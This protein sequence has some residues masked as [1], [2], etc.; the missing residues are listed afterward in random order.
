MNALKLRV[1]PK[2][3]QGEGSQ[4]KARQASLGR[5]LSDLFRHHGVWFVGVRL[6]RR[7]T[8]MSKA[9][10]ISAI[11]GLVVAQLAFI[12]LQTVNQGIRT[13][14][15]ELVG[16]GF[17]NELL[18]VITKAHDLRRLLMLSEGKESPAVQPLLEQIDTQLGKLEARESAGMDLSKAFKFVH[19]TATSLKTPPDDREDAFRL[20][21]ELVSQLHRLMDSVV[22]E[23]GLALDP[24]IASFYLMRVST[25]QTPQLVQQLGRMRDIGAGAISGI[26][27][28][29]QQRGVMYGDSNVTYR[30]LEIIFSR[31]ENI[32]QRS[33]D[34]TS[35][36]AFQDAFTPVNAFM[37][38]VRKGVLAE[39]G[40]TGDAAAFAAAGQAAMDS[41]TALTQRSYQGLS[42]LIESR[43]DAQRNTRNIQMAIMLTGM[44]VAGYFFYCFYLVTRGGMAEVT[45]HI[46]AMARGD[47]STSPKPWGK[48]EAAALMFS[49]S[50][51]QG[52]MR[53]L[54]GEVRGCADAIFTT[55][56]QVSSGAEDLSGRTEMAA[57]SLQQTA[58]AMEQI[59]VAVKQ[60]AGL[61]QESSSLG[62]ENARVAGRGEDVI[63][64]VVVTMQGI[65]A[66]SKKIEEII[67]VIDG[68]AFQTNVLSLNAAVEAARAGEQGRGFAV[69]ASEVRS[70][71][72]RSADA[73]KDIKD[74]ITSSS[75]QT[76]HGTQIVRA[77]GETMNQLV[78]N[79]QSMSR[80][81]SDVSTATH[82]QTRGMAE[83]SEAVAR[84]D[85][86]TQRNAALVEQTTAAATAMKLKSSELVATAERFILPAA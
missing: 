54:I 65:Q 47:L 62:D 68:I 71:A 31:Y 16:I 5:R 27:L 39:S 15:S 11:F 26:P 50:D 48:D 44:L 80:M 29:A 42:G 17:A 18:P 79:A 59:A 14:Q 69:V 45:R 41:I 85:E 76:A 32:V 84:L 20:A 51:M 10:I 60:T 4:V 22:E 78:R 35:V 75:E 86:D 34:L 57:S 12:F 25:Q 64:Q 55:S 61:T 38:S 70:L 33:P 58:A 53:K 19:D 2:V 63:E 73:A 66:S 77:A 3:N 43:I 9:A 13:S 40:P 67:G 49:I 52:S 24:E 6:F 36:L 7:M 1:G 72:R 83:V 74:L 81:L 8:F 21:D 30:D 37:R 82:E 23:S 46:D 56:S 28:T